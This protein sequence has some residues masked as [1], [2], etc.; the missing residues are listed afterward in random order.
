MR[1]GG[2]T[3]LALAGIPLNVIQDTGRW[4]SEA[5]KIYVRGHP[6]LWLRALQLQPV[7]GNGHLGGQVFFP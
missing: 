7:T 2:A 6:L 4:A 5:F 3:V 1:S